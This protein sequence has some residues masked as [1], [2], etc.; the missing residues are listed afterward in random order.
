MYIP[1]YF[2]ETDLARLDW[3]ARY[4]AFGTLISVADG[5]PLAT[6][7]PVL[8]SR[9]GAR[10]RLT[11]HWARPNPQWQ[12][13][14]GQRVLFIL[15]GPHAYISPRWYTD[16]AGN[17]PTWDYATA[18]LYGRVHLVHEPAA[19]AKIVAALAATYEAG[20]DEPWRMSGEVP[21]DPRLRGII[22]FELAVDD[23]QVKYKL[24]QNHSAENIEGAIAALT[25]LG[26][27][28]ARAVATLMREA[29]QRRACS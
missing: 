6:H 28:E 22:G 1:A 27:D 24:N 25:A 7:L 3:L 23:I 5:A 18:H 17:V 14:E 10:V 9:D 20:A 2:H 8:Y 16:P 19:L 4:D 29:L 12:S 26:T 13:I 15:R 11:G 21:N